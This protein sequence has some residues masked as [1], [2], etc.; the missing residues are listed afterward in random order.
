MEEVITPL[1][2]YIYELITTYILPAENA[3][4]GW[5]DMLVI[6]SLV[7]SLGLFWSC[8]CRPVWWFFKWGLWGGKRGTGLRK[9]EED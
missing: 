1:Y 4:S 7:C 5:A 6:V 3:W 8:I 2:N 9:K